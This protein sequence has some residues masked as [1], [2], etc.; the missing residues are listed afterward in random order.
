MAWPFVG[1]WGRKAWELPVIFLGGTAGVAVSQ[2]TRS[3]GDKV[4]GDVLGRYVGW[5]P[6]DPGRRWGWRSLTESPWLLD[7]D[8]SNL[9]YASGILISLWSETV[10]D[11]R[12]DH[13][14]LGCF[15]LLW[16]H[17]TER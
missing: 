11:R 2:D 10:A 6:E 5:G 1:T 13:A 9:R 12:P 3:Q 7:Q 15:I 8:P 4:W 17:Q 14:C 16:A